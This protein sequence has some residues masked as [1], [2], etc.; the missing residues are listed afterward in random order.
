MMAWPAIASTDF[1]PLPPNEHNNEQ[2]GT[3]GY[4]CP[5]KCLHNSSCTVL[6]PNDPPMYEHELNSSAGWYCSCPSGYYG[7]LCENEAER[8][9]DNF[10]Y[11]GSKCLQLGLEEGYEYVCDCAPAYSEQRYWSGE[12]CQYPST[13]FCTDAGVNGR[14][15]CTNGGICPPNDHGSCICPDNFTGTF[16]FLV[17]CLADT[18]RRFLSTVQF[19]PQGPRCAFEIGKDGDSYAGCNLSCENGGTCQKGQK[20][21]GTYGRFASELSSLITETHLNFEHCVCPPSYFGIR[22]E[23]EVELCKE[24]E[25]CLHGG[26][27]EANDEGYV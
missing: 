14:Q 20:D 9:G 12:F 4:N 7:T 16:D 25:F 8:C 2:D 11:N 27:C 10:C 13:V 24:S 15:F 1:F 23:Y 18:M 3:D 5:L 21:L 26:A 17:I 6:L 22:C 19:L